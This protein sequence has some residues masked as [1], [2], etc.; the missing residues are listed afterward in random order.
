MLP[1]N[2]SYDAKTLYQKWSKKRISDKAELS[3]AFC[4]KVIDIGGRTH[5]NAD[6]IMAIL[7]HESR[8]NP[9]ALNSLGYAGLMQFGK[10]ARRGFNVPGSTD[11]Q[12]KQNLLN[13]SSMEQ[14]DYVEKYINYWRKTLHYGANEQIT[15]GDLAAITLFPRNARQD[16]VLNKNSDKKDERDAYRANS[17]QDLD[18]DGKITKKEL[19]DHIR[20]AK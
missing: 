10:A 19:V 15:L 16:I 17:V 9:Q 2:I 20:L 8:F 4:Q 12:R 3:E 13:M 18:G 14:L 11:A 1:T 5:C 6:D 7:F